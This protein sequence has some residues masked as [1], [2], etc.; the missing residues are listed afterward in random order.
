MDIGH[1]FLLPFAGEQTNKISLS[2]EAKQTKSCSL[3]R[4]SKMEIFCSTRRW[5]KHL[6]RRMAEQKVT[7]LYNIR[8]K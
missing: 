2:S 1:T 3:L 5:S 8:V 6:L 7:I 4:V